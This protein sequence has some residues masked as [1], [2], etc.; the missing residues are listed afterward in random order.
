MPERT[1][2]NLDVHL[3]ACGPLLLHKTMC[4]FSFYAVE[5]KRQISQQISFW[6]GCCPGWVGQWSRPCWN[7]HLFQSAFTAHP[8]FCHPSLT[9]AAMELPWAV[10]VTAVSEVQI[11]S[12]L[13]TTLALMAAKL[14]ALH[15]CNLDAD[16]AS[17]KYVKDEDSGAVVVL[18][19]SSVV[20]ALGR[21]N[22]SCAI[23]LRIRGFSFAEGKY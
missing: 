14:S 1:F 2:L 17:P 3:Q 7:A 10:A 15:H 16:L 4:F 22:F 12:S 18:S 5:L 20:P 13:P 11:H 21:G 9:P 19:I 8:L 6:D 23:L